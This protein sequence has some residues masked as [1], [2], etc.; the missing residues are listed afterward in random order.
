MSLGV[1]VGLPGGHTHLRDPG[2]NL[3]LFSFFFFL[4]P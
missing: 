1:D 2:G 4:F 3:L